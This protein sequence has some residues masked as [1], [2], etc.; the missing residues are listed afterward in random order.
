MPVRPS[1][2]PSVP[3]CIQSISIRLG[4]GRSQKMRNFLKLLHRTF[5][6]RNFILIFRESAENR[7]P[8]KFRKL[9]FLHFNPFNF[10]F[11][12]K[13]N[14]WYRIFLFYGHSELPDGRILPNNNREIP[15][16]IFFLHSCK[17]GFNK[18]FEIDDSE[19]TKCG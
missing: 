10:F 4:S 17:F 12:G 11:R 6:Y 7:F 8:G 5:R 16:W 2:R 1:I 15:G 3:K 18:G 13:K 9:K 14:P 19:F